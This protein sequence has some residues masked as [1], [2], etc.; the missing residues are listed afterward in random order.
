MRRRLVDVHGALFPPLTPPSPEG[1][2]RKRNARRGLSCPPPRS[3][4]LF[5][6][7]HPAPLPKGEGERQMPAASCHA[8]PHCHSQPPSCHSR[9]LP[10]C[11]S[12]S[13]KRESSVF[14][15]PSRRQTWP[16]PATKQRRPVLHT[17]PRIPAPTKISHESPAPLPLFT[18]HSSL[19]TLHSS[20]FTLHSPP[21]GRSTFTRTP[22]KIERPG[23]P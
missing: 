1:R 15:F 21:N 22:P 7:P 12:R 10:S 2:G 14:S 6:P 11:H 17:F 20:L 4:T 8:R 18:L 9:N 19:S 16:A 5:H 13:F 23:V 3:V